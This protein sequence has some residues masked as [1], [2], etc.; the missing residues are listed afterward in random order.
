MFYDAEQVPSPRRRFTED[1]IQPHPQ[2]EEWPI[3]TYWSARDLCPYEAREVF[4]HMSRLLYTGIA[5]EA[6]VVQ[7]KLEVQ[8]WAVDEEDASGQNGD[9]DP[10]GQ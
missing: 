9:C 1:E 8:G 6:V 7:D 2:H 4:P 5:N 3:E 10:D